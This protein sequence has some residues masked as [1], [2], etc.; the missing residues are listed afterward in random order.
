MKV[1][2]QRLQE[3]AAINSP[4]PIR[5]AVDPNFPVK[6]TITV[7]AGDLINMFGG[8]ES[9]GLA[10]TDPNAF[11]KFTDTVQNDLNDWFVGMGGDEWV[12][13]GVESGN[14]DDFMPM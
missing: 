1:T 11:K 5:E 7:K 3:L 10:I 8:E 4:F 14:Y 2:K 9:I 6:L 13:D 12:N